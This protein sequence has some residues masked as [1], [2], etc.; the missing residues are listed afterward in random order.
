MH[1]HKAQEI[2]PFPIWN[3]ALKSQ[4]KSWQMHPKP[5]KIHLKA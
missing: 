5:Q 4:K 3:Q 1:E 2:N